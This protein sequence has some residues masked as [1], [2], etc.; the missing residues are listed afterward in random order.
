[1]AL[2]EEFESTGNWLFKWRSYLPL[3]FI[4]VS[5]F[6]LRDYGYLAHNRRL[7]ELWGA[8]CLLVSFF[9][10]AIRAWTVGHTPKGT[11]GRTTSGQEAETLNTTGM[12]SIVR[13]PLYLGNFFMG[14]GIAL[15][16]HLW[17]LVLIYILT[18]WIYYERIMFAEEAY[19]SKEFGEKFVRWCDNTPA[20]IPRLKNYTKP[21]LPFSLK[22]VLKREYNGFFAVI[23]ILFLFRVVANFVMEHRFE[24]GLYWVIA[25]SV[26]FIIWLVLRTLKK[27][28]HILVVEGR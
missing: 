7:D 19:L 9:G 2:R 11:S 25:F 12:Y 21:D 26:G 24:I 4:A 13:H 27:K 18:F 23:V 1:M 17:W 16:A 5:L 10:L 14:L 3:V 28:T 8:F 15:F 20:F 6:A 22:N